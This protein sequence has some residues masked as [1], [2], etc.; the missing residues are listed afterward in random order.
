MRGKFVLAKQGQI[1]EPAGLPGTALT[2]HINIRALRG[3]CITR[4][5]RDGD[6]NMVESEAELQQA[7][8]TEDAKDAVSLSGRDCE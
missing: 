6:P 8:S 3:G 7:Q 2:T 4:G 5:N 1:Y